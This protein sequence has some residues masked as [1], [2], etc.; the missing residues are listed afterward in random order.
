MIGT[1]RAAL[2]T[3]SGYTV[4]LSPNGEEIVV[5]KGN[6]TAFRLKL[7]ATMA[8]Q[9]PG[10]LVIEAGNIKIKSRGSIGL[11]CQHPLTLHSMDVQ[12]CGVTTRLEGQL[13]VMGKPFTAHIQ[14]LATQAAINLMPR[15]L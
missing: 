15:R 13:L 4:F 10:D 7:G 12:V 11:D 9:T 5:Q 3:R 8:I 1:H 6:S 14:E 2:T